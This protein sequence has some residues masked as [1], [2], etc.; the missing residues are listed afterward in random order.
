M[1]TD[2]AGMANDGDGAA[3]PPGWLQLEVLSLVG[4]AALTGL[5]MVQRCVRDTKSSQAPAMC[6]S[7]KKRTALLPVDSSQLN[8]G[9]RLRRSAPFPPGFCAHPLA[10]PLAALSLLIFG[11]IGLAVLLSLLSLAVGLS[12]PPQPLTRLRTLQWGAFSLA[13]DPSS[14]TRAQRTPL[15]AVPHRGTIHAGAALMHAGAAQM[16]HHVGGRASPD[17]LCA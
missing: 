12:S 17:P 11:R 5:F 9:T 1:S 6:A 13:R 8:S 15:R 2:L 3:G 16:G 14:A 10:A 7:A 4:L